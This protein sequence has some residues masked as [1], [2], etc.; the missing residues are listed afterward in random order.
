[1]TVSDKRDGGRNENR[2]RVAT[3]G[4]TNR[5]T[6]VRLDGH[7]AWDD[8]DYP[9]NV[10]FVDFP[11]SSAAL[12]PP[13]LRKSAVPKFS[14]EGGDAILG[15]LDELTVKMFDDL[16]ASAQSMEQNCADMDDYDGAEECRAIRTEFERAASEVRRTRVDG[17]EAGSADGNGDGD[18]D[19]DDEQPTDTVERDAD[20][21]GGNGGA[22]EG[23]EGDN[24]DDNGDGGGG[25][26]DMPGE[27]G[28]PTFFDGCAIE[29]VLDA[30]GMEVD[31]VG[32]VVESD[33]SEVKARDG[34]AIRYDDIGG[35]VRGAN[36]EPVL[37][38]DE[39]ARASDW[40]QARY[41]GE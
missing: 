38:R 34:E 36:G 1:M 19:G 28:P 23:R 32:Y 3:D 26:I 14:Q 10:L 9:D 18:G 2:G 24:D 7:D 11:H 21:A 40:V 22:E 30:F 25:E 33:G 4:G 37:I 20:T 39:H 41:E 27:S 31:D 35:I 6:G 12:V 17:G 29:L 8:G 15:P 13:L 16:A 5:A